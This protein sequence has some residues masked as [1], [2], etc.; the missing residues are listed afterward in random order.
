MK[1]LLATTVIMAASAGAHSS[2][3]LHQSDWESPSS[4]TY[5]TN[6]GS[7]EVVPANGLFSSNSLAFNTT[8][9]PGAFHYDQIDYAINGPM[10]GAYRVS[11]DIAISSLINSNNQFVVL[12]DTPT[13]KNLYFTNTGNIRLFGG[14]LSTPLATYNEDEVMH[15][16]MGF[17]ITNSQ[18]DIAL[19]NVSLYSGAIKGTPAQYLRSIRFSQGLVNASNSVSNDA[20]VFLDNVTISQ[21]PVPSSLWLFACGMAGLLL[22]KRSR[23]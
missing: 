15:F 1:K 10:G 17:D 13:V 21:L 2:V 8:G 7:A 4:F 12:F 11:F 22:K 14:G 23:K 18:W 5:T 3:L 9:N 16:D 6:F 19:N 20:T